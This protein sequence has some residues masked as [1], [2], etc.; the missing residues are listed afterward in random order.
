MRTW[1]PCGRLGVTWKARP[2][3][4]HN[5]SNLLLSAFCIY[6]VLHIDT[7]C[8][9][10]LCLQRWAFVRPVAVLSI[11]RSTENCLLRLRGHYRP[12][13]PGP[14]EATDLYTFSLSLVADAFHTG[15]FDQGPSSIPSHL[16]ETCSRLCEPGPFR[17]CLLCHDSQS[18]LSNP[19]RTQDLIPDGLKITC[20]LRLK[21][22][23]N[24]VVI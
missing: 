20:S 2:Q 7:P 12:E 14:G 21:L 4:I 6:Y 24:R 10:F 15:D 18:T 22:V 5:T 13:G 16:C 3:G 23:S 11:Q 1:G 17:I 8:L 9:E 19:G